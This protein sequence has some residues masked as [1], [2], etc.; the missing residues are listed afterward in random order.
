MNYV[1]YPEHS[2]IYLFFD[3]LRDTHTERERERERE[4]LMAVCGGGDTAGSTNTEHR[5]H[6]SIHTS[7]IG[8]IICGLVIVANES[9]SV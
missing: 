8:I 3:T 9:V 4:M 2:F 1:K 6:W 7:I 5:T